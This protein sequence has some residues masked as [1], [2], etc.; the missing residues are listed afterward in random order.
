MNMGLWVWKRLSLRPTRTDDVVSGQDTE[1]AL[2]PEYADQQ[3]A[4]TRP[5]GL[6]T[7]VRQPAELDQVSGPAASTDTPSADGSERVGLGET[8]RQ[9][10]VYESSKRG[11]QRNK[12]ATKRSSAR[13]ESSNSGIVQRKHEG[14]LYGK[15][16]H[17]SKQPINNW[18]KDMRS[19]WLPCDPKQRH[20]YRV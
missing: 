13:V 1:P 15:S 12:R 8:L 2:D 10:N 19:R 9:L 16:L 11:L 3:R 4:G 6:K 20:N 5:A 17:K 7:R 18:R 14:K